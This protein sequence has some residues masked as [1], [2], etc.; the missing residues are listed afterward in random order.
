MECE[1]DL[2]AIPCGADVF[3]QGRAEFVVVHFVGHVCEP[4]FPGLQLSNQSECSVEVQ[5]CGV[6]FTSQDGQHQ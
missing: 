5:V 1:G 3:G 6:W 2:Q 4:C